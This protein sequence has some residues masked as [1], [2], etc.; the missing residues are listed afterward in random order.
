MK[1]TY[2]KLN[3]TGNITL[4]VE[5]PVPRESQSRI[6]AQLMALDKAAEQVGFLEPASSERALMR[7][8]MMGGEFC[9]NASICA[10][11]LL[12][13]MLPADS[14]GLKRI[15]LEVSGVPELVGV[16]VEALSN[17]CWSATVDMPFPESVYDFT[18]FD[19][20]D[21][22]TFPLVRFPGIAHAI[23][24]KPF[25]AELAERVIADW[26]RQAK[27]EA[28]GLMFLN[29]SSHRL[30]PYVYVASTDTAVWESSCAS[31]TTAVAV[32]LSKLRRKA[33]K[34][35]LHEPGGTLTAQAQLL[36]D[37]PEYIRLTGKAELLGKYDVEIST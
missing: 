30:E 15:S 28:L 1:L 29:E 33:A 25:S 17:D 18:F 21:T 10:A 31:G 19:G 2:Y 6:A 9:G 20:F 27:A 35:S 16:S 32:W 22:Y 5:T 24:T 11:S 26:C 23:V 7:L 12:S 36:S 3:P 14:D 37:A 4:I 34:I 13:E 8:Q